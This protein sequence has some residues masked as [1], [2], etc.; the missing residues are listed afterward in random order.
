MNET[1]H[2]RLKSPIPRRELDR[3]TVELQNAMK[4]NGI[5]MILAQNI[6]QY[7]CGCNRYM[8]D[9]TAENNYPQS[10]FL[11]AEGE[12]GYIACSGP[13]LDLYPPSHLLRIGKPYDAAPYFSPFN[14]TNDWEGNFIVRWCKDNNAKKIGIA[15]FGM[16]YWNYYD[17]IHSELPDLEIVDASDLFDEIR[18]IKSADEIAFIRN[19]AK[20]QDKIMAYVPAFALPGVREYELRAKLMQMAVDLG[21]EEQ[22]TIIGSAPQ[23]ETFKPYPSFFQNRT[24]QEGDQLYVRLSYS[25]PGGYYVTL[26]RM[27]CVGAKPGEKMLADFEEAVYAQE[28]L[29]SKLVPGADPAVI[30]EV[31]NEFLENNGYKKEQGLFA[32][33]QGYDNIERP[34]VQPGET[35]KI[36]CDMCMAV[37]TNLV[38]I[39]ITTYC[40]DSYLIGPEGP[41]RLH[42]TEMKVFRS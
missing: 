22:I 42:K 33:G 14:Y 25:G 16:F 24:L 36:A 10:S 4:A 2:E 35:M 20:A 9:T 38:G 32:Y 27:F 34:S 12:V 37:L 19:A 30:F 23:G 40:A 1:Y 31:Y 41:E 11:P 26:G 15:G 5:D 6:T 39:D 18:A 13:P 8:T 7:L 3:R 28:Y 17:R 29:A 21:M